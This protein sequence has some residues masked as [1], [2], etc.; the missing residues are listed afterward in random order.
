MGNK[1]A[2]IIILSW[3]K[4]GYT[5]KCLRF[6]EENTNYPNW[7]V[8]IIDNGSK[9]G[10]PDFLNQISEVKGNKYRIILNSKNV[11]YAAGVNQ[12]IRAAEGDYILLL[13]NDVYVLKDWLKIMIEIL[14][15]DEKNAIIGPKLIYPKTGRI[16][17]AG[18]VLLRKIEHLHIFKNSPINHPSANEIR[19]VDAV[20]GACMLIKKKLFKEIGLFDERFKYGGFE[21]VDFC[22]RARIRRYKILYSPLSTAIHE[23]KI[24]TTQILNYEAI[25]RKN[26]NRFRRKWA[27]ILDKY[28]D[29]YLSISFKLK[30]YLIYGFFRIVPKRL[31][32]LIKKWLTSIFQVS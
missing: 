20:T 6:L 26:Y 8:I 2:S 23:E 4:L 5:K 18:I 12:G 29:K 21:D 15:R 28:N 27:K 16:Q 19:Y 22:L 24:S 14:E 17:H 31:E 13:N 7:E 32:F 9:D 1:R 10:T 11:G 30:M 3:N 25:S